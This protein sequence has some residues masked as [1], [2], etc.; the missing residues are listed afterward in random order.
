MDPRC[1]TRPPQALRDGLVKFDG[2]R[3]WKRPRHQD[4]SRQG[5]GGPSSTARRSAPA[6]PDWRKAVVLSKG[7]GEATIGFANGS[8]GD[9]AGIGRSDAQARRRRRGV[10]LPQAGHGDHRQAARCRTA[11]PCARCPQISGGMLV[12]EVHTGRVMAMQGGFDVIGSAYNRATQALRQ[13]G[14]AFKP[15]VYVTALKNGF[16]PATIE[17][18]AP[19][20]V[21]QGAG[22]RQ[23]CFVNFDR[24]SAGP[25]TMRWGRAVAQPDDRSRRVEI[26]MPKITDTARKLGVGNYRQLSVVRARRRRHDRASADQCLCDP[27]Q[28]GPLGEAD[29]DRLCPGPQRQGHLPHRQPLRADGQLQCARLG[30]EGDAAAAEPDPS[31]AS[32]R[33]PRSRWSTSWKA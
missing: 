22:P 8:T 25:H 33:W 29:D 2:G 20:C 10:R 24:R 14:S 13:P 5:L 32:T 1:R 3:G 18:D 4:R 16:T 28:P 9:F 30:R 31:A 12:E 26:G 15:I 17:L 21:W 6:F 7:G 23:K 27:R 19:F 11:M